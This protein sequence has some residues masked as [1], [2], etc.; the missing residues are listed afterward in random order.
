VR[1]PIQTPQAN[2]VAERFVRTIRSECLDWL[3]IVN[4]LHL[5]RAVSVFIDDYNRISAS[6]SPEPDATG[7]RSVMREGT[8]EVAKPGGGSTR[9]SSRL[10][11]RI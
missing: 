11:A 10:V 8:H 7:G 3:L 4:T 1:T 5:E 6:P 9:S 2:G